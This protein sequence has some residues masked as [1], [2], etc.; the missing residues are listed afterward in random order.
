LGIQQSP[1]LLDNTTTLAPPGSIKLEIPSAKD[2]EFE[3]LGT[4]VEVPINGTME[5]ANQTWKLAQYV[6]PYLQACIT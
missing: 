1:I 3:N 4:T 5:A 6:V 2:V